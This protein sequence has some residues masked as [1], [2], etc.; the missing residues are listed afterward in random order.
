MTGAPS[1][2]VFQIGLVIDQSLILD[3]RLDYDNNGI[4]DGIGNAAYITV[5][6]DD[7]SFIKATPPTADQVQLEFLAGGSSEALAGSAGTYYASI[8]NSS[9]WTATPVPVA[10]TSN[11]S[12]SFDYKTRLYSHRFTDSNWRTNIDDVGVTYTVGHGTSSDLTLYTYVGYLGNYED[13]EM[14][15]VFPIDWGNATISDPFLKNGIL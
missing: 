9:Y 3:K 4:A 15:V 13:P 2:F 1:S 6:L 14:M 5:Y 11:T 10:L 7:V 12:V 8:P